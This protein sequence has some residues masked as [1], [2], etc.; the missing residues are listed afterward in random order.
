MSCWA[1]Q[2][3]RGF[4]RMELPPATAS[5]LGLARHRPLAQLLYGFTGLL[6]IWA[7]WQNLEIG[8][9]VLHGTHIIAGLLQH[10]SK[11]V[12][13]LG[14]VRLVLQCFPITAD[15]RRIVFLL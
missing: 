9:V 10:L 5:L 13:R 15:C 11:L 1:P 3:I 2:V 7:A 6:S 14:I 4:K 8:L 12:R